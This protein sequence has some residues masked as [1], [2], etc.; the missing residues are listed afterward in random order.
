MAAGIFDVLLI[1]VSLEH[2]AISSTQNN[3]AVEWGQP[4]WITLIISA[5]GKLRQEKHYELHSKTLSQKDKNKQANKQ[6]KKKNPLEWTNECMNK[7]NSKIICWRV[8]FKLYKP[9]VME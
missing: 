9:Q 3:K 2:R 7:C 6:T 1:A 8:I 4:W 5:P